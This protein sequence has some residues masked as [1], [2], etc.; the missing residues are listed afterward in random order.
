MSF[1]RSSGILLHVTSLPGQFGIGDLGKEAYNFVDF[2]SESG[3]RLWQILPLHPTGYGHSPYQSLSIFAG[4]PLFISPEK[5]MEDGFLNNIDLAS[6]TKFPVNSIDYDAVINFKNSLLNKSFDIFEIKANS[7]QLN[8]FA[9]FSKNNAWWLD[10]YSL[11][12]ALR[13]FNNLSPWNTWDKDIR[14]W[15]PETIEHWNTKLSREIRFHKY[16]QYLFSKQWSELKTYC[17]GKGVK[18]IG[19]VPIYVALD[20]A[21]VW[22]NPHVFYINDNCQPTIVAGVPPDY[23]SNTGQLWGNPLYRWDIMLKDG[24]TWWVERLKTEFKLV[25]II[26]LDHFRGFEKYWAV[27]AS[28]TTA[29][30][31]TWVQG[32]GIELFHTIQK[33]IGDIPVITEDL[34]MITPEVKILRDELGFPGMKVLQFAF[35]DESSTNEYKPHNYIRNC[36]VYTGT[37]DNNTTIGWFNGEDIGVTTRSKSTMDKERQHVLQ[38]IGTDGHEI[39]WDFI[40]IA[41]MSIADIAIIPLQDVLGLGGVAR[42]NLPGTTEGNWRWRFTSEMLTDGIKQKLKEMTYLYGR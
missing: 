17:H 8:D 22:S 3:Q 30:N 21:E 37:H 16:L 12:M 26:R 2:L 6:L 36:V 14:S 24:F 9:A 4:N 41:L 34:G 11:F 35:G 10:N 33:A 23:F 20:S 13:D 18:I 19:D 42:M 29:I 39:N 1:S 38:Y 15:L 32:P 40:R 28:D 5:L 25:D 31:G 27:P 7:T